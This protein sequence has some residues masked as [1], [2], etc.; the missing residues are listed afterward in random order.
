MIDVAIQLLCFSVDEE[1]DLIVGLNLL[2]S[3]KACRHGLLL[4]IE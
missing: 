2:L 4:S 1:T 3:N